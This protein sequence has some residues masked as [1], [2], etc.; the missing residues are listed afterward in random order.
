MATKPNT[1]TKTVEVETD[2]P[3]DA[4]AKFTPEMIASLKSK[5]GTWSAV[6]RHLKSEGLSRGQIAKV[7][8]KRYQHVRNVDITPLTNKPTAAA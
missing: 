5:L 8:G 4:L 7:T 2:A 6:F 1:V 3:A